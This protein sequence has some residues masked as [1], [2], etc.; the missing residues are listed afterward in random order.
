VTYDTW[1]LMSDYDACAPG[2]R[3]DQGD[4]EEAPEPEETPIATFGRGDA[5]GVFEEPGEPVTW[6]VVGDVA[7]G[8]GFSRA[9]LY[10]GIYG[11]SFD[12]AMALAPV[13][14]KLVGEWA[15][16]S[17]HEANAALARNYR[18]AGAHARAHGFSSAF[19]DREA[20]R[21]E[22]LA[23]PVLSQATEC[24]V[25]RGVHGAERVHHAE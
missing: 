21:F 25:C 12:E 20:D 9:K 22:V 14:A 17:T 5:I 19:H 15:L 11:L 2:L 23:V 6:C 8:H 4:R 10:V 16:L 3:D 1:K 18:W 24:S 7:R 13:L